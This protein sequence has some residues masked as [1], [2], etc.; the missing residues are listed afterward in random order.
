MT[1]QRSATWRV[2]PPSRPTM[3]KMRA[4]APEPGGEC[5]V[6]ALVV[7]A[8]GQLRDVVGG[9]VRLV[10]AQLAEV[11]DGVARVGRRAAH[12]EDEEPSPAGARLG[13]ARGERVERVA[14]EGV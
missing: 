5:A 13:E 4:P 11:V 6:P 10:V 8:R 9:R 12:A 3:P 1:T 14:V 2:N 7:H